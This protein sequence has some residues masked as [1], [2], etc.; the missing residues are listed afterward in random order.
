MVPIGTRSN[1]GSRDFADNFSTKRA[2]DESLFEI[3]T[4]ALHVIQKLRRSKRTTSPSNTHTKIKQNVHKKT[5]GGLCAQ[6]H[7]YWMGRSET[8][9]IWRLERRLKPT[10]EVGE[11][12]ISS[13]F[14]L[15]RCSTSDA[16]EEGYDTL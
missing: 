3:F 16:G 11:E 12:G 1:D 5:E 9:T 14:L 8:P 15:R 7:R 13:I 4:M 6:L 10:G 2:H